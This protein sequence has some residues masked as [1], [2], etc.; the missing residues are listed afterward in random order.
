MIMEKFFRPMH[1][2]RE[3]Y[4]VGPRRIYKALLHPLRRAERHPRHALEEATRASSV[5]SFT[6][7]RRQY[8]CYKQR[9]NAPNF[10]NCG[11]FLCVCE[12]SL[13][14]YESIVNTRK[15]NRWVGKGT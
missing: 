5:I 9:E 10:R 15:V 3:A 7:S 8:V 11:I 6:V 14:L 2:V 4:R 12:V 13:Y 1:I